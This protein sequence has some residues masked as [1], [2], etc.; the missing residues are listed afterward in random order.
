LRISQL[1][2]P[3]IIEAIEEKDFKS[4]KVL[5]QNLHPFDIAEIIEDLE[6]SKAVI[7][8]RLL[9]S[10]KC[11]DVI[12]YLEGYK[13]EEIIKTFSDKQLLEIFEEIDDDDKI[14]LFEEL[15]PALV[16]KII[17]ILPKEERDIALKLLNYP[18][19]SC[20]RIMNTEFLAIEENVTIEQ[21][22]EIIRSSDISDEA[23]LGIFIISKD[24][25]LKGYAKLT[26]IVRSDKN[27]KLSDISENILYVSAYDKRE[28]AA[29]IMKNYDLLI[30]PV[31]DKENRILG[32]ITIDDVMDVMEEEATEDIYRFVGLVDPEAK[33]FELSYKDKVLKRIPAIFIMI[34]LGNFSGWVLNSFDKIIAHLTVLTFFLP[35]LAN[36][37]GIIGSQA[38]A[39]TIRAIA[40]GEIERNLRAFLKFFW[41]EFSTILLISIFVA[42]GMFI[43]ALFRG[44]FYINLA[45]V[46]SLSSIISCIVANTFGFITP[47]ILRKMNIDPA[48]VGIPLITTIGDIITYTAYFT[49]ASLI[50]F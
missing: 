23:L 27:L 39:F 6:P 25:K 7:I 30:L 8:L 41:R 3:E 4:L 45:F 10:E 36:T 12:T 34:V 32:I 38:S 24:N 29:Q 26:K 9:D 33:Y 17:S 37:T 47:I 16:Q 15:P 48:G 43:I 31:V 21:A 49:L 2:L 42:L 11:S 19:D 1:L 22:L 18:E 5:V 40:T 44:N 28:I 46:V 14:A 35:N 50:L 13:L 20:G